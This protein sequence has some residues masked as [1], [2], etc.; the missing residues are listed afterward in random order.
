MN[1][2]SLFQ[3]TLVPGKP[4]SGRLFDEQLTAKDGPDTCLGLTFE[5]TAERRAYFN[6][7][8]REKLKDPEF[9]KIDGFP[10]GSDE[11][12]LAL[13][14]PPYYTAC[15]NPWLADFVMAWETAKT[16]QRAPYH[17]EPFATDVSE[18]KTHAIYR[19][20]AYH[21][22]V[23]HL[24]IVPLILHY[25]EP[26]DIVLDGFSGSGQT[27]VAAQWCGTA[28]NSYRAE[29]E[30]KWQNEG[31]SAPRWGVRHCILND[32]SPTA[33]FISSNYNQP[34]DA[35]AFASAA[36]KLLT[37][38]ERQ[39]GWMYE[40]RHSDGMSTGHIEY[41]V[42]S[43]VFTCPQC[44]GEVNFLR[45]A[46]DGNTK[47][48]RDEFPCPHCDAKQTKKT[49][50][51]L[52]ITQPD[53]ATGQ[54]I[55]IPKREPTILCYK[56]GKARYEKK[57]DADD[58][59]LLS[60]ISKIPIPP[61]IPT[62]A[63]PFS[64]MWEA[65]RMRDKGISHI[66]HLFFP[67]AAQALAELWRRA[68]AYPD[69]RLRHML[70]FTVEQ[71]IWGLSLLARYAPTHY[72]QVNQYLTGAYYIG[73]QI[74]EC[75]PWYI[76]RGKIDRLPKAFKF[77]YAHE[78]GTVVAT[79]S[80]TANL[81]IRDESIDYIFT[82]PP[83]GENF[84]YAELNF[85]VEAWYGVITEARLDA[86]V[87]RSKENRNAQKSV[88]DYRRLMVSCFSE[89]Y[90]VL[91]PGR[92]MTVVFSNT[93]ASVWNSLQS[94]LQEAGFVVANVSTLDKKQGSFKAVTT[95]VAVKQD[96]VISAYK[97]NGGF[98]ERFYKKGQTE[99]GVWDFVRTHLK[100]L[101]SVKVQGKEL[102]FVPERDPRILFD[103]VVAYYFRQGYT[104][105]MSSQEF[106]QDLS[107]R[108]VERDGMYFLPEQA[109]EYDRARLL[110]GN[111]G[112][113]IDT[114]VVGDEQSAIL[115][116]RARLN[117][118]PQVYSDIQPSFMPMLSHLKSNERELLSLEL[119]LNQNFL[120]YDGTGDVP[121][122]IH[123]YLSSNWKGMRNLQKDDPAL[124]AKARDR[125]YVPDPNKAGDIEKLREVALLKEF[126]VLKGGTKKL[127]AFRLE[128][129]RAG[130][131]KSWTEHDYATILDIAKKIPSTIL[132]EDPILLRFHDWA[133][134]RMGT[135]T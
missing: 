45:E 38:I 43:E 81:S 22:K 132:E 9:R 48:V 49:L 94:A 95:S 104:L 60:K 47:R 25:T 79:C 55:S 135:E 134:T 118:A 130:F 88:A 19:A 58:L 98:G 119:L 17:R 23:P 1:K 13:S 8:L 84:P 14:D 37:D 77:N 46:L 69:V 74:V 28:P 75:S 105:P 127:K 115:W 35:K 120:C 30:E 42:W 91:K 80:T 41:T 93:R 78:A 52:Y 131:K 82:D 103:Q 2:D 27:G 97:P 44:T 5:N 109:T 7:K 15:P 102:H 51:R 26:G 125:W 83:F 33:T 34:F 87:D 123:A 126:E 107:Q 85:L 100:Y 4:G 32:L 121:K 113:L 40:T 21:T 76:L 62:I 36:R 6:E 68:Q 67:R 24:A 16:D 71:A 106:Q 110:Y 54:L 64:D 129:V 12:I 18:G 31:R 73:S 63:F 66:H 70:M 108:F 11:D 57:P 99:E 92:W 39:L 124:R 128:V 72:S 111:S 86:I 96:L 3:S 112:E 61:E 116:L 122:Q 117:K 29:M 53:P 65:P 59:A 101:P 56:F 50:D 114:T 20:H 10:I 89:Y 90:R 133:T